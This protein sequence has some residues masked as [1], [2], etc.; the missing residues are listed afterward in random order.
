MSSARAIIAAMGMPEPMPLAVEQDVRLDA[1]VL[2]RPHL[3][4]G[5]APDWI[6]SAM[7]TMP[8]SSQIRRRPARNP[9]S[10]TM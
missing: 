8:C 10:G 9:G 3:A 4:G 2:D 5:P 6:S 7:S 1:L